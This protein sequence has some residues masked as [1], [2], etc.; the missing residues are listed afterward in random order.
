MIM[1]RQF[2]ALP[3]LSAFSSNPVQLSGLGAFHPRLSGWHH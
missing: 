1:A 3:S 2:Y